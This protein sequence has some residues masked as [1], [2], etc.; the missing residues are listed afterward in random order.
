MIDTTQL[1]FGFSSDYTSVQE[2]SSKIF[3]SIFSNR[4]IMSPIKRM[5]TA[6]EIKEMEAKQLNILRK[7]MVGKNTMIES[8]LETEFAIKAEVAEAGKLSFREHLQIEEFFTKTV[9]LKR[10]ARKFDTVNETADS[11]DVV[12]L[13]PD[14]LAVKYNTKERF[15]SD[16][17]F[18]NTFAEKK[19]SFEANGLYCDFV[20]I[21][22]PVCKDSLI[23][24]RNLVE[25]KASFKKFPNRQEREVDANAVGIETVSD[26]ALYNVAKEVLSDNS[27]EF[28]G[29]DGLE[30]SIR[31]IDEREKSS[32]SDFHFASSAT[33]TKIS[34][35]TLSNRYDFEKGSTEDAYHIYSE[36]D[37]DENGYSYIR[38]LKAHKVPITKKD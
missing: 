37:D 20:E 30:V 32:Y 29:Y 4:N 26:V 27:F 16:T 13:I 9:R 6:E 1:A 31:C 5:P 36:I 3:S 35:L 24:D 12:M 28:V 17:V 14:N 22:G 19:K 21:S 15:N 11:V 25:V 23:P 38:I 18:G 34:K 2:D 33:R 8:L 10:Y 7:H